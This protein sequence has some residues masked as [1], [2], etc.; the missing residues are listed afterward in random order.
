MAFGRKEKKEKDKQRESMY[1]R[2]FASSWSSLVLLFFQVISSFT[3]MI[4]ALT[5][6]Q[7]LSLVSYHHYYAFPPSLSL[8]LCM[9]DVGERLGY[10]FVT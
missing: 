8:S 7:A 2:I 1:L 4:F 5:P 3:I 6:Q 10:A 9:I